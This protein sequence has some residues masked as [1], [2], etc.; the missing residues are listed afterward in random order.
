MRTRRNPRL[1][2]LT[3]ALVATILATAPRAS[4]ANGQFLVANCQSDGV[5]FNTSALVPHATVGMKWRKACKL[6]TRHQLVGEL[7]GI[8]A[9]VGDGDLELLGSAGI[10]HE[11]RLASTIAGT[12]GDFASIRPSHPAQRMPRIARQACPVVKRKWASAQAR[13]ARD[14]IAPVDAAHDRVLQ[15]GCTEFLRHADEFLGA[16]ASAQLIATH[17]RRPAD[18]PDPDSVV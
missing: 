11:L 17:Q 14:G 7:G 16:Y 2:L 13:I 15:L 4:A 9:R 8:A 18:V 12:D 6:E 3:A 5:N 1:W 10:R